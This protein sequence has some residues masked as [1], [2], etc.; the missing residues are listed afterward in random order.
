MLK[1]NFVFLREFF[2]EFE[3]TGSLFPSSRWAAEGL[4][5]PLKG[6]RTP[7]KV[8]EVGPGSGPVTVHI[9]EQM[10]DGDELVLC[11][12]NPRFMQALKEN[13]K[14]NPNYLKHKDRVSFFEGPV[15]NLEP[16]LKFDVIVC[17]IPF[18]NLD[19]PIVAEIF[20]KLKD[21]SSENT[22]MTY[23]EYIGLR[24]LGKVVSPAQRRQ[25]LKELDI[26]FKDIYRE[27]NMRKTRVW[28]NFL[29]INIYTLELDATAG[30][31]NQASLN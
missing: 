15:Q 24:R 1:D 30:G 26:F 17:A 21:I 14:N 6:P 5:H 4:I 9:L 7:R 29:P 31:R 10:L 22:V 16:G 12:I 19:A 3:A 13:L 28:R 27:H 20:A 18:L 8:I 2:S 11:E 23:Y 25:R